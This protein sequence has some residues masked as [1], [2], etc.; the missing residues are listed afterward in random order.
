MVLFVYS[1]TGFLDILVIVDET[2]G[3]RG[4][5]VQLGSVQE[6]G[7]WISLLA[8]HL[9]GGCRESFFPGFTLEYSDGSIEYIS[10]L[11]QSLL[12]RYP[13]GICCSTLDERV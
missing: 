13:I 4:W 6:P 5:L 7:S 1:P 10:P 11:D 9:G 12:P 8:F 2:K 3:K